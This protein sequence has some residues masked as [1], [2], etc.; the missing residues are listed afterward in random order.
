METDAFDVDAPFVGLGVDD[1]ANLGGDFVAF[2]ENFVEVKVAGN[3]A[4]GGLGEGAGGVAI[5]RGFEDGLLGINDASIDY[6]VNVDGDVITGNDFLF[7]D[8]HRGSANVDFEHFVDVRD[9]DAEA[10]VQSAGIAA[11]AE[12]DAAFVL[13]D[14]ADARDDDD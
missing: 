7:R 1:F 3:V 11:E 9:D 6:G 13:V 10:G 8:V 14:N 2:A 4:E 5:V 12:D